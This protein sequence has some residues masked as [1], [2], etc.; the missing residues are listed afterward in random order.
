MAMNIRF[1]EKLAL[2]VADLDEATGSGVNLDTD[3]VDI[4][5]FNWV[6]G[7]GLISVASGCTLT[8]SIRSATT[9]GGVTPATVATKTLYLPLG[10]DRDAVAICEVRT[11]QFAVGSY[12]ACLR[13]SQ[14]SGGA[15]NIGAILLGGEPVEK[16]ED[17]D[18][19]EEYYTGTPTSS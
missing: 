18:V 4:S 17:T 3:W 11:D 13:V 19:G 6:R 14:D 16:P 8:V 12:F 1:C 10:V 15:E 5:R 9:V 7:L 2:L